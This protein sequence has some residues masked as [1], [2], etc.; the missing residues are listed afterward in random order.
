M[1]EI[2][3]ALHNIEMLTLLGTKS[4]LTLKEASLVLGLQKETVR[5]L[6]KKGELPSYKPNR[7]VLYFKKAE[8]EDWMLRNRQMSNDEIESE[9]EKYCLTHKIKK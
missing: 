1:E 9:A 5:K 4:V 6:A 3:K 7:N 2:I 8:L